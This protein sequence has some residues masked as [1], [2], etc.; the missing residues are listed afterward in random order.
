M[1]THVRVGQE[2]NLAERQGV[3]FKSNAEQVEKIK[4]ILAEFDIGLISSGDARKR[5]GLARA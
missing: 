3:L 5:L 1:G 2:D 4:R